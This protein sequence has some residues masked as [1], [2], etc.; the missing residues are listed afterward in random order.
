MITPGHRKCNYALAILALGNRSSQTNHQR[1]NGSGVTGPPACFAHCHR[2]SELQD[3]SKPR[4]RRPGKDGLETTPRLK[5]HTH[6]PTTRAHALGNP[7]PKKT[8]RKPMFTCG[9]LSKWIWGS[10]Q[11]GL[12][13]SCFDWLLAGGAGLPQSERLAWQ[14][15]GVIFYPHLG[16]V[17]MPLVRACWI[18][19][20][21]QW[22]TVAGLPLYVIVGL[23]Y[24]RALHSPPFPGHP[25]RH[26]F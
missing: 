8:L 15:Y 3:M 14:L 20:P 26:L 16:A 12:G 22:F 19:G 21:S 25:S 2:Y 13:V 5:Q 10:C 17:G 9:P 6:T 4:T 11:P 1:N 18:A 23:P 7:R 24:I